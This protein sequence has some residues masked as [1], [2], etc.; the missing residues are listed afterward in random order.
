[1]LIQPSELEENKKRAD[2]RQGQKLGDATPGI[3]PGS[4]SRRSCRTVDSDSVCG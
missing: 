1:M 3:R 4:G 2:N